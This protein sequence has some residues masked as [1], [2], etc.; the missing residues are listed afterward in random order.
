MWLICIPYPLAAGLSFYPLNLWCHTEQKMTIH[1]PS[2]FQHHSPPHYLDLQMWCAQS[3]RHTLFAAKVIYKY[4]INWTCTLDF[5]YPKP[6]TPIKSISNLSLSPNLLM[7]QMVNSIILIH[8]PIFNFIF[9]LRSFKVKSVP[10]CL[11]C[12]KLTCVKL[13]P[14]ICT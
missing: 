6:F 1:H 13:M 7:C 14:Y 10:N 5:L 3:T 8:C 11:V 12:S 2:L 4:V 9:L